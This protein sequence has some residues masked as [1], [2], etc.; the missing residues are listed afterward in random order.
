MYKNT[1]V[2][3]FPNGNKWSKYCPNEQKLTEREIYCSAT[4]VWYTIQN[5]RNVQYGKQ[6]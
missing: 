1:V 4:I 3:N 2:K 5:P 6:T